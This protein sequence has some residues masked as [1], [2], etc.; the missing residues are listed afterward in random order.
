[1]QNQ[2]QAASTLGADFNQTAASVCKTLP[3]GT[4]EWRN[5]AGQLHRENGPAL[6]LKDGTEKWYCKGKLHRDLGPAAIHPHG[7]REWYQ[8]GVR[9]RDTGPAFEMGPEEHIWFQ[10]GKMCMID[11]ADGTREWYKDAGCLHR[12]HG[13]AIIHADG[14][15]EWY[16]D[17]ILWPEGPAIV[18]AKKKAEIKAEIAAEAEHMHIG[19]K[20]R[21]ATLRKICLNSRPQAR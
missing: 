5:S 16:K 11:Y 4:Q 15:Q 1:M 17:G 3:N 7:L 20:R 12:E 9:H 2:M 19:T 8:H 10:D 18:A 13:P 6:I 21:I 14:R